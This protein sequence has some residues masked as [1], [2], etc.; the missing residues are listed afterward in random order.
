MSLLRRYIVNFNKE[1]NPIC[2]MLSEIVCNEIYDYVIG[3]SLPRVG[4]ITYDSENEI[5]DYNNLL[6]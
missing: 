4:L 3:K 5:F 1:F 6:E 2:S